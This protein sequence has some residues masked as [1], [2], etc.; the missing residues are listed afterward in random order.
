MFDIDDVKVDENNLYLCY[1]DLSFDTLLKDTVARLKKFLKEIN[2]K[3]IPSLA[4]NPE[5]ISEEKEKNIDDDFD[6]F[7]FYA[8]KEADYRKEAEYSKNLQ[9]QAK[10]E[11]EQKQKDMQMFYP[12]KLVDVKEGMRVIVEGKIFKRE[13]K[14]T[15]KDKLLATFWFTD[16]SS[17]INF[18][19]FEGK[20]WDLE[21][22]NSFTVGKNCKIKGLVEFDSFSNQ[23]EINVNKIE[24]LPDDEART[25]EATEKRVELHLHTK[26]SAMDAV[27]TI[28]DYIDVAKA[29]GHK[30]IAITDHAVVQSFPEAQDMGKRKDIKIIYGAEL[31]M[32]ETQLDNVFNPCETPLNDGKY[33]VFDLETTGLS[34]RYDR[35][36]EFGAV[37]VENGVV[38]DEVD[39]FIN[40][41]IELKAVTTNLTGITN[42]MVRG[43]KSISKA[44]DDIVEFIGD[45]ILVSHNATFDVGFLNEALKNNNRKQLDNPVVDTLPL[46]RYIFSK[47]KSHTLGAVCR[48]FDVSYDESS[49]HRAI[50]DAQVLS[51]V[52]QCMISTLSK[53]IHRR[54]I[55]FQIKL[56]SYTHNKK[57]PL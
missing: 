17:S 31:Y 57:E 37:K 55:S 10:K 28:T 15:K 56:L 3:Y 48:S 49:A 36:I 13:D 18:K 11:W 26:M 46:S 51:N 9:I 52:W 32:V 1:H 47:Q 19:M 25:D 54:D 24:L 40:P 12:M 20:R 34:A 21:T 14:Q 41:D 33:V 29:M 23:I 30:A 5:F 53:N 7:D 35:I 6:D 50:Y 44:L 39:F 27:S 42:E 16:G 4:Y 8:Q 22:I 2:S 38:I 45:A 43:G